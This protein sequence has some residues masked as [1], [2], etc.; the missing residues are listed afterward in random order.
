MFL[1]EWKHVL[2]TKGLLKIILGIL[3]V[4]SFYAVIF[5]A[6]LWNPYANVR[7]LPVG[8][9]NQDVPI[10]KADRHYQL[11]AKLTQ[12]L[13]HNHSADFHRLTT[14]TAQRQLRTGKIYM[15]I[16]IPRQFSRQATTLGS[17]HPHAI[18]LHDQTNAGFSFIAIIT[19][20]KTGGLL[21]GYK[22]YVLASVS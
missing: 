1:T 2:H 4:P 20:R 17:A 5:L 14:A 10:T 8:V 22:P 13:V 11:G 15:V 18:N 6:S 16:T 19:T 12:Q 3:L 21:Q 9:V 7:H